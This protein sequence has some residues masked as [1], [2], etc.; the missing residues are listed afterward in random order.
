MVHTNESD[1]ISGSASTNICSM[2]S[3]CFLFIFHPPPLSTFNRYPDLNSF[4]REQWEQGFLQSWDANDLL[5]LLH[6]WQ[7]GDIS[8][9]KHGG[10]LDACLRGIKAKGLIMPCKTDLYFPVSGLIGH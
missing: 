1:H 7:T 10:D 5:T 3:T 9:V 6:T 4:L 2:G 8:K